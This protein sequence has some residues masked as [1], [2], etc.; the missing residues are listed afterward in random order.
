MDVVVLVAVAVV[1]AVVAGPP[2]GS[3]LGGGGRP[4]GEEE[5][6]DPARSGSCGARSTGGTQQ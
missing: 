4:E 6:D 2:E 3:L 5:L 1:H